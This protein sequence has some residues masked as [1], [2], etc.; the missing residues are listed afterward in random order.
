MGVW[1]ARSTGVYGYP[2]DL[3]AAIA[4]RETLVVL[5]ALP[6]SRTLRVLHVLF[7]AESLELYRVEARRRASSNE[8][9]SFGN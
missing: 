8:D 9:L 1:T 4:L 2:K 7:D 3:A 6:A 5:R